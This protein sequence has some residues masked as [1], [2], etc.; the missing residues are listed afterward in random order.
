MGD[1]ST[2][3]NRARER[4]LADLQAPGANFREQRS[5]LRRWL[6]D[7]DVV[8]AD[9]TIPFVPVPHLLDAAQMRL[10]EQAVQTFSTVLARLCDAYL[11]HDLLQRELA[12]SPQE[13][14]LIAIPRGYDCA[15]PICRLDAFMDGDD[16]RFLE[17]NADSP[18]GIGYCDVLWKG[19]RRLHDGGDPLDDLVSYRDLTPGLLNAV[20]QIWNDACS[21]RGQTMRA[22]T[23]AIVDV[24]GSPSV[25]EF[26]IL[27]RAAEER[28]MR[29][30]IVPLHEL[31]FDGDRLTA[32]G[33]TIDIVYRR[34]LG[35]NFFGPARAPGAEV[36]LDAMRADAALVFN[37]FTPRVANDKRILG[38]LH[39]HRFDDLITPDERAVIEATIPWT[40]TLADGS[41]RC[42]GKMVDLIAHVNANREQLVIKPAADY[43][44]HGVLLG[45][46]LD[47]Q[48]WESEVERCAR[49]GGYIVQSYISIP[50]E[51]FPVP[52]P[53][54]GPGMVLEDRFC[55]INPFSLGGVYAGCITR[56]STD[57]VINVSAGG[58]LLPT[59]EVLD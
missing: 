55:N 16:L 43:G 52:A 15:L 29:S 12:L 5:R 33:T 32:D 37:P 54:G 46:K 42:D 8:F 47:Q 35:E 14:E 13:E 18:A 20:E 2:S 11:H 23:L 17:F 40:A 7:H 1:R 48:A 10:I 49:A 45:P 50:C 56:M 31:E 22:P 30:C 3:M 6:R 57:P 39:G 36:V 19:I 41:A 28:G 4:F 27:A 24:A 51:R 44:G 53:D 25:P 34:A 21:R 9:S 59:V 38:V 26:R 58:G